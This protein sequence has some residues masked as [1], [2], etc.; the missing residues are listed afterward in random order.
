MGTVRRRELTV[1]ATALVVTLVVSVA[2]LVGALVEHDRGRT[3]GAGDTASSAEE[4]TRCL[5]TAGS[6]AADGEE[7]PWLRYA[8]GLPDHPRGIVVHLHGD[9][10][11]EFDDP[12][13]TLADLAA[14]ANSRGLLFLA[15]R[16]PDDGDGTTW[17]HDL[18]DNLA[19]LRAFVADPSVT[20]G[21]DAS[22]LYWSGYSG[23]AEMISYGLLAHA[24]ELVTAGALMMGGGGVSTEAAADPGHAGS[25]SA[26]TDD[27]ASVPLTWAVGTGD[28]G[29][30]S[31]DGFDALDAARRGSAYYRELGYRDTDLTVLDGH[32]HYNLPQGELLGDL[33]DRQ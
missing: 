25:A 27:L 22:H 23:G 8:C 2:V 14:A 6:F 4:D 7:S 18:G 29:T 13:G 16:T 1:I 31:S 17:W 15:P 28:D 11:G 24:P 20:A 3:G 32:D 12:E 21:A 10:A 9:G 26:P 19:W 5:P 30:T 33:L